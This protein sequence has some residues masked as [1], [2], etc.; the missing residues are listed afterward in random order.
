[1]L[2][3]KSRAEIKG[4]EVTSLTCFLDR[5]LIDGCATPIQLGLDNEDQIDVK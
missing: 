3:Q 5:E 4:V 2:M 1:M